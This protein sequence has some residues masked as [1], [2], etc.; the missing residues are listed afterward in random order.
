M[1]TDAPGPHYAGDVFDIINDGF[2]LLIAHPPCTYLNV[3]S[4][5]AFKDGPYHQRVKPGTL[6]GADRRKA[7][8]DALAFVQALMD[9]H[10]QDSN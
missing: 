2:D 10:P 3:A 7:R 9:D 6:V 1:P 8:V 4:A 5:W